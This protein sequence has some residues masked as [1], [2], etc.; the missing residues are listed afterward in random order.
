M[1][2]VIGRRVLGDRRIARR[3]QTRLGR[4]RKKRA[5]NLP[6][7]LYVRLYNARN[8]F[9]H[10]NT[11]SI[12]A[13]IPREFAQ[14]VRL[15]DAAPLIYLAALDGVLGLPRRRST[16]HLDAAARRLADILEITRY[17]ALEHAFARAVGIDLNHR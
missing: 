2:D 17:N 16:R 12:R 4:S 10:G 11:L 14:G 15:L 5:L 7:R 13:F 9:L 6:Q 3:R 8:R 1:L